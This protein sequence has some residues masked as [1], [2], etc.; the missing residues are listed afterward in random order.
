[1]MK[2]MITEFDKLLTQGRDLTE[3]DWKIKKKST[4]TNASRCAIFE[5]LCLHPCS[6]VS[7]IAKGLNLSE[8]RVRWHL[9]KLMWDRFV[10]I[11]ENGSTIFFPSNMINP[12]HIKIFKLLALEKSSGII[13]SIKS[14]EGLYQNELSRQLDLNIRTIM[15]YTSDL[16]YLGLIR[17]ASDGKYRRYYLTNMMDKL[18]ENYIKN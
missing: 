18:R 3:D 12:E 7:G 16:E 11:K 14:K 15:K 8:S 5:Y 1:M 17:G 4:L 6:S 10:S 13:A 9:E 2:K